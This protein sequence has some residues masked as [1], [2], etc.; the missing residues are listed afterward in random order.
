MDHYYVL[1][2]C[3]PVLIFWILLLKNIKFGQLVGYSGFKGSN[4]KIVF[5]SLSSRLSKRR[6]KNRNMI[7]EKKLSK[8]MPYSPTVTQ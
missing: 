6:I 1:G 4:Y 8:P 7:E 2:P 3:R 5:Q